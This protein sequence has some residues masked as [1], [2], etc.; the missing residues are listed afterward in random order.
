MPRE[1][2]KKS[3]GREES[4][5][6]RGDIGVDGEAIEEEKDL[7][8]VDKAQAVEALAR[9][10]AYLGR[11]FL[12]WLLWSSRGGENLAE[13]EG[14][15]IAVLFAG[16]LSLRGLAGEAT[17]LEVKGHLS[18][19]SEVVRFAIDKGLLVH[20]ARLRMQHGE[21][22]YEVTLDAEHFDLKSGVVPALLKDEADD[23]LS[24]RL[25]LAERLGELLDTLYARFLTVR[26]SPRWAKET[27]PELKAWLTDR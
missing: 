19:Y 25:W 3:A 20:R 2:K 7:A 14:E 24:E 13:L 15:G 27:V 9:N 11:E 18:A 17:E 5:F 8:E 22:V 23:R 16:K 21:K 12:T 1:A 10:R 26:K 6:L 4:E